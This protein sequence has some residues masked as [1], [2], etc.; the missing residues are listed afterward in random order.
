MK[1]LLRELQKACLQHILLPFV[2]WIFSYQK[3]DKNFVILADSKSDGVPFSLKAMYDELQVRNYDIL[4]WCH[5]Y[6]KLG[7]LDK[8]TK[9]ILFMKHYAKAKYVFICDYYLPIS[10]CIK[11]EDTKVI[12]LWHASGLQKKIGFDAYD[13]LGNFK[14]INPTKNFDFASLSSDC[15]CD[16]YAKS[17]QMDREKVLPFGTSRS[18]LFF[19]KG[20]AKRC[21][22]QF[23]EQY[24]GAVGKKVILWA[25]SFRG[26]GSDAVLI[27]IE[28][29][30]K[31]KENLGEEYFF[32]IKIHPHLQRKY[33]VENCK[34]STEE[35]Y[36]VIDILITDYA[37]VFYDF[38]LF[39]SKVIVF[40][41][42]YKNYIVNRGMYIDYNK[43][44]EFPVEHNAVD[45]LG[46]IY[47]YQSVSDEEIYKYK[48]KFI[49]QNDGNATKR[50]VGYLEKMNN[51]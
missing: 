4:V 45:L 38:L 43:E 25:P 8:L 49:C 33:K 32:I 12:Q 2:Y 37:S 36:P 1:L 18:D 27:G 15:V 47:N 13:D 40:V 7:F 51:S 50:I 19:K 22:K 39:G 24:P 28:D 23:Y 5:N 26:N 20:Y 10:S 11:K 9:S 42:D 29:I 31:L 3:V 44:F 14:F 6:D 41:P 17:W 16:A 46:V 30:L 34:I 48:M 35:L 21:I